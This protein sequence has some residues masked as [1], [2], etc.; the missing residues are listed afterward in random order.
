MAVKRLESHF[1]SSQRLELY[2]QFWEPEN[3]KGS[4]VITH[5]QAEHGDCYSRLAEELCSEGWKVFTWD[6]VGHGRSDGK[7]GYVDQFSTYQKDLSC[8]I[9]HL[10]RENLLGEPLILF[11]HSMG[12]LISLQAL[13]E[14]DLGPVAAAVFS[15]PS[16]GFSLQVP[17][18]K[19]YMA[20]IALKVAPQLTLH[21]EIR[22]SDLS[23][24]E[25]QLKIYP[26]DNLRHDRI[27][28]SVFFGF[29]EGFQFVSDQAQNLDL[30]ILFQL[31]GEDHIASTPAAR[32]IYE[33]L[34]H[35]KKQLRI[36]TES[37]HEIYNDLDRSVVISD[38]KNFINS[39][40][41]EGQP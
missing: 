30:P 6:L 24:D 40:S 8:F 22:F 37:F 18:I 7:R 9:D 5:G 36:Y 17:Q 23:R 28:A 3:P 27:S 4:I 2:F 39:V 15:S 41:K 35:P 32:L 21:N 13:L 29:L 16:L 11:S 33:K 10:R 20:Q 26:K 12:G 1:K 31:A 14:E 34:T 38:L 19:K 25:D